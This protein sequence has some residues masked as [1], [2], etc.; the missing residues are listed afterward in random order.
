MKNSAVEFQR[1]NMF[2]E[3][4]GTIYW[5]GYNR[6]ASG[7]ANEEGNMIPALWMLDPQGAEEVKEGIKTVV[8]EGDRKDQGLC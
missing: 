7:E 2:A 5:C 4:T 3:W 6:W 1:L 8:N